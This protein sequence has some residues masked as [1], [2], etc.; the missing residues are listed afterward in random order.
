MKVLVIDDEEIMRVTLED[1]LTDAGHEVAVSN[2]A[3]DGLERLREGSFD[4]AVVDLK[5]PGMTGLEFL[6][7][8]SCDFA[9][10][11]VIMMTAYG[12]VETA[13]AA[14]KQGAYDYLT[15][16]FD[17]FELVQLLERLR[18]HRA[19]LDENQRLRSALQERHGFH[20][21]VGESQAM[22]E[23]YDTLQV[24]CSADSTVLI[25]GETGTG[26]EMVADAIHYSSRRQDRPLVKV[27]CAALS[28]EILE[29]ELFG[30]VRGAFTGAIDDKKGR[31]ELAD[32][33]TLF[34]DEVDDIPFETQVKLLRVLEDG[35]F[36]RVG[37][38]DPVAKDVRIIAATKSDLRQRIEMGRFRDDLFYRLNQ[39]PVQLPPLRERPEDIPLLIP[40]FT[41]EGVSL[42]V[43]PQALRALTDYAWPGNVRELKNVVERLLLFHTGRIELDDLPDEVLAS[44]ASRIDLP[45]S[46]GSF[47]QTME[48][49]E[50]Q[51]LLGALERADGNQ[52]EAARLLGM[53]ASTFRSRLERHQLS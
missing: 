40:H 30:H 24:V 8:A 53:P 39:L 34:L 4:V 23:L 32:R 48:S 7:K 27:S 33:G 35:V 10:L 26:K 16:P 1:A 38:A 6:E 11:E 17:T 18:E 22:R 21:L 29:S 49:T 20:L 2:R 45:V 12:T 31:F 13:V 51:L 52:R 37:S 3:A 14:M 42:E 5:M 25:T 15:K 36:E 44:S 19:I 41:A 9:E 50:R 43:S 47:E 28:H 46:G